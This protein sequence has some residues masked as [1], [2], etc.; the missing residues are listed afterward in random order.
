MKTFKDSKGRDWPITVNVNSAGRVRSLLGVDVFN[1][2][3]DGADKLFGDPIT[4]V[5][6][7]FVLVKDEADKRGVTDVDFGES[8][9]GD[10][11]ESATEAFTREVADFFP[12][13]RRKVLNAVLD[14]STATM[15]AVEQKAMAA[16]EAMDVSTLDAPVTS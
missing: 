8:L 3:T 2:F 12:S 7:L 4:L 16:I 9:Y 14:K 5:N 13:G 10:A 11:I 1:L 15:R 6:V